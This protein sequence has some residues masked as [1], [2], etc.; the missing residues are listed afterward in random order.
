[1]S[2]SSFSCDQDDT[3]QFFEAFRVHQAALISG[4]L[5]IFISGLGFIGLFLDIRYFSSFF[6]DY[7]PI[8]LTAILIWLFF[9]SVLTIHLV[10][11]LNRTS[12]RAVQALLGI[13][14]LMSLIYSN[15][16]IKGEDPFFEPAI[17][18]IGQAILSQQLTP[19][20]PV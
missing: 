4:F 8:A 6:A 15:Q 9:G 7:K 16:M 20:S 5:V 18:A 17:N 1:M 11:P 13:I 19:L 14:A 12:G 3:I 2:H 10:R